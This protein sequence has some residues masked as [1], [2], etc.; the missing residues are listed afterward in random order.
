[1]KA[2][3]QQFLESLRELMA[4]KTDP[5]EREEVRRILESHEQYFSQL[6]EF[7][8]QQRE[9]DALLAKARKVLLLAR[10]GIGAFALAAVGATM[11][12]I[13]KVLHLF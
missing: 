5:G 9:D 10:I 4:R 12:F 13:G 8:R 11:W 1:M 2:E 3:D 7:E 6:P